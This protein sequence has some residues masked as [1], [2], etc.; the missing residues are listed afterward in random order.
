[1]KRG[2]TVAAMLVFAASAGQ[3]FAMDVQDIE[4]Y[5]GV[6][7]T[8]GVVD[9]WYFEIE[10]SGVGL[11]NGVFWNQHLSTADPGTE[12]KAFTAVPGSENDLVYY[13]TFASQAALEA[14]YPN[15]NGYHLYFNQT[16]TPPTLADFEDQVLLG[17]AALPPTGFANI[18]YPTHGATGVPLNPL[19][20]WDNIEGLANVFGA[21]VF[22]TP[23]GDDVYELEDNDMTTTSWQPGALNPLTEYTLEVCIA[24]PTAGDEQT[25]STLMGDSFDVWR[26]YDSCN[27]VDFTTIPEP[28]TWAMIGTG[29]L[30][31]IGLRRRRRMR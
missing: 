3:T 23:D 16:K 13:E 11:K 15:S 20:Q 17:F 22:P 4:I 7:R 10:V 27:S 21:Y 24:N 25:L 30:G 14:R 29:V 19:Y 9:T 2:L 1:M 6:E 31:V 26:A 18:T 5:C 8:N 12:W 28:T